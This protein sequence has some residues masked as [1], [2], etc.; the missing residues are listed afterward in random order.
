MLRPAERMSDA[1]RCVRHYEL[2]RAHEAAIAA[3]EAAEAACVAA[4]DAASAAMTRFV[5]AQDI[6]AKRAAARTSRFEAYVAETTA[7]SLECGSGDEGEKPAKK[8]RRMSLD[9]DAAAAESKPEPVLRKGAWSSLETKYA[10]KL[11]TLFLEG[12]VPDAEEGCRLDDFLAAALSCKRARIVEK[13]WNPMNRVP[14]RQPTPG[15]G[16]V[17]KRYGHLDE[18]NLAKLRR[19]EAAWLAATSQ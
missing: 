11:L 19:L 5:K 13:F 14:G 7:R 9:T 4:R 17:F 3:H 6:A 15:R 16:A 12:C 1:S 8:K 2:I 10:L 18:A